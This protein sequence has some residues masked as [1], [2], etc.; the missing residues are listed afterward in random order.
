MSLKFDDGFGDVVEVK[1]FTG[2]P[3]CDVYKVVD[4]G[5]EVLEIETDHFEDSVMTEDFG[6]V[7]SSPRELLDWYLAYRDGELA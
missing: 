7:P 5:V 2:K 1:V 6:E 3:L 4:N